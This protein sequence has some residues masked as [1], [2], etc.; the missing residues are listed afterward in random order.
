ME[1]QVGDKEDDELHARFKN[2]KG[3]IPKDQENFDIVNTKNLKSAGLY[4]VGFNK[5]HITTL[6]LIV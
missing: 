1:A 6:S 2:E 4:Y 5:N 3:G